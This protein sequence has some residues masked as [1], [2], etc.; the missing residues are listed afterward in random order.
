M[1]LSLKAT[2]PHQGVFTVDKGLAFRDA[3]A[4]NGRASGKF[5]WQE[6]E[7]RACHLRKTAVHHPPGMPVFNQGGFATYLMLPTHVLCITQL[8]VDVHAQKQRAESMRSFCVGVL[9]HCSTPRAKNADP[10]P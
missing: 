9:P 7:C 8:S 4:S 10:L 5:A 2:Q 3:M 1:Y 6:K